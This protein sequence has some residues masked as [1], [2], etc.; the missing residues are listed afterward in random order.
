[1]AA[2]RSVRELDV[3]PA[4]AAD[5]SQL[6]AAGIALIGGAVAFAIG[7][8]IVTVW[9]TPPS[10]H[11]W[12]GMTSHGLWFVASALVAVGVFAMVLNLPTL[13]AGL[14]AW[15][16]VGTLA[17]GA[18][19]GLQWMAWSYVDVRAGDQPGYDVVL[20][21]ITTPF[22]AAHMLMYSVLTG[23]AVVLLAT[24]LARH[25]GRRA[26]GWAGVVIGGL[27][28]LG[29]LSSLMA[30]HTG[31]GDGT[32]LFNATILVLPV[33]FLW[34]FILGFSLVRRARTA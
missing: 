10:Q 14:G 29:A 1:M 31:G 24:A 32:V 26:L 4:S 33:T 3:G 11:P 6:R 15:L 8:A 18:L 25:D 12:M 21:T 16:A 34:L 27:T 30:G 19:N 17:L 28:T 23:G 2:G 7:S 9:D 5:P 13:R 20:E 22:G